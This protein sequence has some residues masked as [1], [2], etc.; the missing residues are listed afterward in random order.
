MTPGIACFYLGRFA[1]ARSHLEQAKWI[2]SSKEMDLG[3]A[4]CSWDPRLAVRRTERMP[5]GFWDIQ[6]LALRGAK[7]LIPVRR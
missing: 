3:E 4:I 2:N 5:F 1:Q 7:R 6:K